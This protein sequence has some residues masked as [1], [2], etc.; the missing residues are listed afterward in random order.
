MYVGKITIITE[1]LHLAHSP[2]INDDLT[3][4]YAYLVALRGGPGH[5]V[6]NVIPFRENWELAI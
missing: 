4:R 1:P 2:R 5:S 3:I 6:G